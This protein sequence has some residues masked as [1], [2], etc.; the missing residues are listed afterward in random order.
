MA[1]STRTEQLDE[2]YTSTWNNRASQTWD[3]IFTATPFSKRLKSMNRIK[4]DGSG[5][6][7]LEVNLSYAKNE[8]ITSLAKGDTISLNDTKFLTV[9]QYE[10][11]YFAG[12]IT[13][14]FTDDAQNKGQQSIMNLANAKIDNLRDS[15][16][17]QME[18]YMFGDG[19]ANSSK[20]PAGIRAYVHTDPT[21]S[22]TV[23]NINQSTNPWWR[24][25]TKASTGAASVYLLS[26]MRNLF[27]NCSTG[28]NSNEPTL[29]VTDQTTYELYE[30]EVVEFKQIQNTMA[31]DPTLTTV[32]FRGRPIIWSSQALPS[33]AI[34]M[35]NENYLTLLIDP[36]INFMMTEWKNVANSL[37]RFA[38][39]VVKM[40][41]V[42]SRRAS[43]GILT[44]V[45]A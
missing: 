32:T 39:I 6:R 15:M 33:G 21:L 23:G 44:G 35:L 28:Q 5:G 45:A 34:Y 3:Q 12:N 29:L 26:D 27:N 41:L 2:F 37:D 36:D 40:Q 20:D 16:A 8:T 43:Q 13:R 30:D 19:T 9:S 22:S 1:V 4:F 14:Y 38:Q 7:Y 24:N 31:G 18:I 10:W 17:D 11:K 42:C 25:K